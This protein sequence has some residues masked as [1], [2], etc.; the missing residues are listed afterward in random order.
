MDCQ[1]LQ[2]WTSASCTWQWQD[3]ATACSFRCSESQLRSRSPKDLRLDHN[4]GPEHAN[5]DQGDMS[6]CRKLSNPEAMSRASKACDPRSTNKM[7]FTR[8]AN[9][10]LY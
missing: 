10:Q 3:Q 6:S 9:M 2:T 1:I 5:F 4:R 7:N 8:N